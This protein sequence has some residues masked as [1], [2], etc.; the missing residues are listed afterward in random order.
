MQIEDLKRLKNQLT[1]VARRHRQT[2]GESWHTNEGSIRS[3]DG[4][5]IG[6][7]PMYTDR[8]FVMRAHDVDFEELFTVVDD[9][10]IFFEQLCRLADKHK[11]EKATPIMTVDQRIAHLLSVLDLELDTLENENFDLK[12][13]LKAAENSQQPDA[14]NAGA[15]LAEKLQNVEGFVGVTVFKMERSVATTGL[16]VL[17]TSELDWNQV[18]PLLTDGKYCGYPAVRLSAQEVF[19]KK[20][21]DDE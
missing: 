19:P 12:T 2:T 9:Y 20:A 16:C 1:N 8:E 18:I 3:D 5:V 15:D 4:V 14:Y 13:K 6:T 7:F 10:Q 21:K 17:C 11:L